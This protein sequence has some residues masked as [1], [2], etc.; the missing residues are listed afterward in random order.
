LAD[1]DFDNTSHDGTDN[2]FKLKILKNLELVDVSNAT[3]NILNGFRFG[4]MEK[5]EC[6]FVQTSR[7][8]LATMSK[9]LPKLSFLSC[10]TNSVDTLNCILQTFPNLESLTIVKEDP[11]PDPQPVRITLVDKSMPNLIELCIENDG[12][13]GLFLE[14]ETAQDIAR[15]FPNL[16]R[17]YIDTII[18]SD[19]LP[20]A[21]VTLLG[22][23]KKLNY[24]YI[25]E[26]ATINFE[27]LCAIKNHNELK[28]I[29]MGADIDSDAVLT[30]LLEECHGLL[31]ACNS[32]TLHIE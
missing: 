32:T 18:R 3:H 22:G 7:E 19:Q 12:E 5:L 26:I 14:I 6:P 2:F 13:H 24:I 8:F 23:L 9:N 30:E 28:Y 27:M 1:C 20:Q 25:T 31:F 21:F 10:S 4:V 17:V 16:K 29:Y 15:N 11:V